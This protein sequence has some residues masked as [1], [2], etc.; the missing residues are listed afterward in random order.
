M[1]PEII[2]APSLGGTAHYPIGTKVG[3]L[4][5]L[6]AQTGVDPQ[7]GR[8]V[9]RFADLGSDG[10][11]LSTGLPHLDGHE[12]PTLSQTW[13]IY[14]NI[15]RVLEA[16]G[17]SLDQV[18]RQRVFFQDIRFVGSFERLLPDVFPAG[19]PATTILQYPRAGTNLAVA[20]Q[21]EVVALAGGGPLEKT[22]VRLPELE[23][24]AAPYPQ[25]TRAG[26]F[27]FLTPTMGL[28]PR[29][30]R[31]VDRYQELGDAGRQFATGR[32]FSDGRDQPHVAQ[33]A[34]A[35]ANMRTV[36]ESQGASINDLVK[37]YIYMRGDMRDV[38]ALTAARRAAWPDRE[39]APPNTT[40]QVGDLGPTPDVL[41]QL[42]V[43]GLVPGGEY[44]KEV[45]R[46]PGGM[47]PYGHYAQV[48][49]AGPLVFAAGEVAYDHK[50][51]ERIVEALTDLPNLASE[52]ARGRL[53]AEKPIVAQAW[54]IY[55]THREILES[56][57]S[58]MQAVAS[59]DLYFREMDDLHALERVSLAFFGDRL[60]P[61]TVMP[62]LDI[63]PHKQMLVEID[64]TAVRNV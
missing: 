4:I 55:G 23:A 13:Q 49:M 19:P 34:Q 30:G 18:L 64:L 52:L 42:E 59:Q 31:T 17:S 1:K 48:A 24:I 38:T 27:L 53:H 16:N 44:R 11:N 57:G 20:L 7:T 6:G 29:T 46:A 9:R 2:G 5:F 50:Q 41:V 15:R 45:V 10:K 56:V 43:T 63:S 58:S 60:P 25:A 14:A 40:L 12:G 61:T 35:F 26:Q 37:Q 28:D 33:T 51:Q 62:I 8:L 22:V 21:I 39:N 36:L 47:E 3:Q 54:C 32:P